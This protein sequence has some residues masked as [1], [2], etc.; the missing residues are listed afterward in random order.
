MRAQLLPN[1]NMLV[2][3]PAYGDGGLQ[4]DGMVE[5]SEGDPLYAAWLPYATN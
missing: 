1:G 3:V 2:P 5:V 4:G